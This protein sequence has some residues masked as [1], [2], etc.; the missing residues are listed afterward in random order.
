MK[1][2]KKNKQVDG[3]DNNLSCISP[4]SSD[5]PLIG[6][7]LLNSKKLLRVNPENRRAILI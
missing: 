3:F 2:P 4:R 6:K 1:K 7:S 5:F